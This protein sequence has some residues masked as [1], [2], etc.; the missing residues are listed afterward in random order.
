M[1]IKKKK[2]KLIF[3]AWIPVFAWMFYAVS[4]GGG[5]VNAFRWVNPYNYELGQINYWGMLMRQFTNMTNTV[6]FLPEIFVYVF[7]PIFVFFMF[8]GIGQTWHDKKHRVLLLYM[9]LFLFAIWSLPSIWLA[10]RYYLPLLPVF[11]IFAVKGIQTQKRNVREKLILAF[12]VV[13]LI[14]VCAQAKQTWQENIAY[15]KNREYP[16][17]REYMY[18]E[19]YQ[20]AFREGKINPEKKYK[21]RKPEIFLWIKNE[22]KNDY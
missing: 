14:V 16:K 13:S 9:V 22:V 10:G 4:H 19:L 21:V 3:F 7:A 11:C 12:V 20:K 15:L 2:I 17:R 18:F 6:I 5:Y 8:V 1:F